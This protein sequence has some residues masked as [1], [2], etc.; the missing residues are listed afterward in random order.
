LGLLITPVVTSMRRCPDL[1]HRRKF[2]SYGESFDPEVL[3][4]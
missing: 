2:V 1:G 4:Y 3:R